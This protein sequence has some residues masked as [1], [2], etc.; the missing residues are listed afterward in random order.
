MKVIA[1]LCFLFTT[2]TAIAGACVTDTSENRE[3]YLTAYGFGPLDFEVWKVTCAAIEKSYLHIQTALRDPGDFP[4]IVE[5]SPSTKM[6]SLIP[7]EGHVMLLIRIIE[8]N[9]AGKRI[10]GCH[11]PIPDTVDLSPDHII[12]GDTAMGVLDSVWLNTCS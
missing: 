5:I 3:K 10:A 12:H 9:L 1:I 6:L 8:S 7:N 2:S 11:R 4:Q